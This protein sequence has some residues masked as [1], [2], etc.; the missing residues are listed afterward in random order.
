[1]SSL[2]CIWV[3]FVDQKARNSRVQKY[4]K[5]QDTILSE[6]SGYNFV[7][8]SKICTNLSDKFLL[9]NVDSFKPIP[10]CRQSPPS[11]TPCWPR[12]RQR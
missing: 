11:P 12:T 6:I 5:F 8:N 10:G 9:Q 1:M 3:Q 4:P 7:R 2:I